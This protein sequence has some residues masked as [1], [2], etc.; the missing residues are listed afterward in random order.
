MGKEI[1]TIGDKTKKPEDSPFQINMIGMKVILFNGKYETS[2]NNKNWF[3]PMYDTVTDEIIG[4]QW[5]PDTAKIGEENEINGVFY[6]LKNYSDKD[7]QYE[8]AMVRSCLYNY[9]SNKVNNDRLGY[10]VIE[11]Q[12]ADALDENYHKFT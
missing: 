5:L 11:S 2:V 9:Y 10:I 4:T 8:T 12:V 3:Y 6:Q 1:Y 7:Y